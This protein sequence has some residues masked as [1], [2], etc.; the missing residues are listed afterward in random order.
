[1]NTNRI[2]SDCQS[3]DEVRSN[4]D[5][6]DREIIGLIAQRS[7]YVDQ[8]S[9]FKKT[10]NEVTDTKRVEANIIK[11][12]QIAKECNLDENLVEQV[13]RDM[14]NAFI[15]REIRKFDPIYETLKKSYY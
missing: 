5:N 13:F 15:K 6:I 12:K 2:L 14:M 4:I 10:M 1:M 7:H 8:A 9:G 3:L 11:V